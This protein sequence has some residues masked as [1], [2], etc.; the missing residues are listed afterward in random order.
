VGLVDDRDRCKGR[1]RQIGENEVSCK[2]VEICR[3][4]RAGLAGEQGFP[5]GAR[6]SH[7]NES[8]SA[9][10]WIKAE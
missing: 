1:K 7:P 9:G 3:R 4:S 5:A 10:V 6:R 8:K 2:S